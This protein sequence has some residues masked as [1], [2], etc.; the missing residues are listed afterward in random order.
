M[1]TIFKFL[2]K[3]YQPKIP[4]QNINLKKIFIYII[5]I[6]LKKNKIKKIKH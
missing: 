1:I 5:Y 3:K 2:T 6:I 4:Y